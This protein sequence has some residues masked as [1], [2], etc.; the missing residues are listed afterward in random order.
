MSHIREESELLSG[1]I[2]FPETQTVFRD[3]HVLIVVRGP[4]H[5]ED[6]GRP[7]R[8]HPRRSGR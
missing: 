5:R 2:D 6:L 7:P 1:A 4:D 3:H 8:L